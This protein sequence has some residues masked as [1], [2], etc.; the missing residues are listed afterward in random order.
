MLQNSQCA[1]P[2]FINDLFYNFFCFCLSK[3]AIKRGLAGS[4]QKYV[5]ILFGVNT[6][7]IWVRIPLRLV[8]PPLPPPFEGKS[9]S[10]HAKTSTIND[11]DPNPLIPLTFNYVFLIDLFPDIRRSEPY[12]GF[13]II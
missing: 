6:S 2:T 11:L 8:T 5:D 1:Y 4:G 9:R 7:V 13:M 10:G 12:I 3:R